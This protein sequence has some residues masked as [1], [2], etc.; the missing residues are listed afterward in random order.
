MQFLKL[1]SKTALVW[2]TLLYLFVA[3]LIFVQRT[4]PNDDW[5][6]LRY[7]SG[8]YYAYLPAT[9]ILND[10]FWNFLDQPEQIVQ[11]QGV[12]YWAEKSETGQWIPRATIAKA[13]MDLPFFFI[14]DLYT[15]MSPIHKRTGFSKPYKYAIVCASVFYALCGL[16]LL[17]AVFLNFF[18]DKITALLLLLLAFGTNLYLYSKHESG[19][20][21]PHS[22]F[23]LSAALWLSLRW[24]NSKKIVPLVLFGLV[25]GLIVLIRPINFILLLP[26]P[27]FILH[28]DFSNSSRQ[29]KILG[30]KSLFASKKLWISILVAI[31]VA[32]P[33]LV[34]WKIQSGSWFYYS[35]GHEEGFFFNNPNILNG[36]FSIRK[37]WFI[38]TPL[39]LFAVVGWFYLLKKHPW[40][41]G[42][43]LLSFVIFVYITFSWWCWWYG[44]GFS[45]RT[46][47]DFYPYLALG[48]GGFLVFLSKKRRV[49][50]SMFVI[51]FLFFIGL[52]MFQSYQFKIGLLHADAMNW[53]VYKGIFLKTKRF[54]D[55]YET[56]SHPD[57]ENQKRYGFEKKE[58]NPRN[59]VE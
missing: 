17:R 45:A 46:L 1:N 7:D 27:F 29:S 53:K 11:E 36:L 57:Y 16:V 15:Q 12:Q 22:F 8:I 30:L 21:H 5:T 35:Y 44:G 10:P 19:M 33:Q 25:C 54:N 14:A 24:T 43:I 50:K 52:N 51:L 59:S 58:A 23:L 55:Y 18:T 2:I 37:G 47:I 38:Y 4:N 13:L 31:S 20:S 56:I 28:A 32:I 49:L 41:T 39:M 3:N 48:L 6:N 9:F 26:L 34:F 40:L 42:A